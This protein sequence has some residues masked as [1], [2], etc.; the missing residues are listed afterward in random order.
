MF[1]T[2]IQGKRVKGYIGGF[3]EWLNTDIGR[4]DTLERDERKNKFQNL[5]SRQH[6]E[7]LHSAEEFVEM[8]R[9]TFWCAR[10]LLRFN[11]EKIVNHGL[12][13]IKSD[14]VELVYGDPPI[15]ERC[16][17]FANIKNGLGRA[18]ATELLNYFYPDKAVLINERLRDVEKEILGRPHRGYRAHKEFVDEVK[19]L[20][21]ERGLDVKDYTEVDQFINFLH[22]TLSRE[23]GALTEFGGFKVEDFDGLGSIEGNKRVAEKLDALASAL[24]EKFPE[25]MRRV[26]NFQISKANKPYT[27]TPRHHMWV[28]FGKEPTGI[29]HLVHLEVLIWG[30]GAEISVRLNACSTQHATVSAEDRKLFSEKIKQHSSDFERLLKNLDEPYSIEYKVSYGEEGEQRVS[31]LDEKVVDALA[32]KGIKDLLISKEFG[33]EEIFQDGFFAKIREIMVEKYWPLYTF[34]L[35]DGPFDIEEKEGAYFILQTGGGEYEDEPANRYQFKEGIPGSV[36]LRNAENRGKFVYYEDGEFYGKGEIGA[37][38][39]YEKSGV[40]Y[41]DIRITNFQEIEPINFSRIR[42]RISFDRISQAGI[43]KI[44]EQDYETIV[45]SGGISVPS[46]LD[47]KLTLTLADLDF[48]SSNPGGLIFENEE[49]LKTQIVSALNSGK[50]IMLVGPPGTGKTEIALSLCQIAQKK[51]YIYGYVLTTATSDWTTFDTIGGYVPSVQGESLEFMP[52]QFLRCFKDNEKP[53]NKWLV[54][55]EINRSDIDKAFGQLFTVLSGQSVELPF[56]QQSGCIRIIPY[57]SFKKSEINQNEYVVPNSWRL[58]ATLNTYD[59]ASLY[60][61]SYAFMRRFAFIYINVPSTDFIEK[62][63]TKY[64]EYWG[65]EYSENLTPCSDAVK[66]IWKSL[67]GSKRPIGPAIVKDMLEFMLGYASNIQGMD[68]PTKRRILTDAVS[69]FVVPQFEGLEE[70]SLVDLKKRLITYC[71]S[72]RIESLFKEMFEG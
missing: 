24:M 23:P 11:E 30:E 6:L 52:G 72:E 66:E 44:S 9:E 32:E 47:E 53:T 36:Q 63:W 48:R 2:K 50:H 54:I 8:V 65:I 19:S 22:L 5:F 45:T 13:N 49:E 17:T 26:L 59:K 31:D 43:Q 14:I 7:S 64:L 18:F 61:M 4:K 35:A 58:I 20:L 67:N 68:E 39:S 57:K 40:T 15:H 46:F 41:Y 69:S 42:G 60:Q 21:Q 27:S 33:S 16:E 56:Y 10:N 62:N 55:D 12:E 28:M 3:K 51:E 29:Q 71:E 34:S 25:P 1:L 70:P 38:T 37:I